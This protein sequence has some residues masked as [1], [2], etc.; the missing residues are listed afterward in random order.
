MRGAQRSRGRG[1]AGLGP[2]I[3]LMLAALLVAA[4][5][6]AGAGERIGDRF[7]AANRCLTV[8]TGAGF[9]AATAD[10]YR[11]TRDRAQ[12]EPFF[13]EPTGLG[14]YLLYDS[15]RRLLAAGGGAGIERAT[16]PGRRAEWALRRAM[17]RSFRVKLVHGPGRLAVA[18]SDSLVRGAGAGRAGR[19]RLV[20]AHG[21]SR[22]PDPSPGTS[23]EPGPSVNP[24]G[25]VRGFVDTHLHITADM[26]AGG[27]VIDGKAYDRYG[28]TR[29]LGL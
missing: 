3:G 18:G 21:C 16:A 1:R 9:I 6:A 19:F 20:P 28:V 7:A 4:A 27:R 29:A 17:P 12:A 15:G 13:F 5:P 26:R 14:R 2:A 10:G 25:T 8:A 11:V 23:G 22:Y 24:D